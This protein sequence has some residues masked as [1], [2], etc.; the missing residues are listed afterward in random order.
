MTH[1]PSNMKKYTLTNSFHR[2]EATVLIDA[3]LIN[4]PQS[5]IWNT[6]SLLADH[7]I[8]NPPFQKGAATA[9]RNRIW[10]KLCGMKDCCCGTVR[11]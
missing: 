6:L 1:E 9:K 7:E 5:Y 3:D 4:E 2:T 10:N 8:C 11:N